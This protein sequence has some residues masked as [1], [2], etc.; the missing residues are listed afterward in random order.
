MLCG[1]GG[2]CCV[3]CGVC[4]V[5]CGVWYVMCIM[6][7]VGGMWYICVCSLCIFQSIHS[8]GIMEISEWIAKTV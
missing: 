4:C 8:E 7:G 1:V 3:V 2:V 6:C 5:V